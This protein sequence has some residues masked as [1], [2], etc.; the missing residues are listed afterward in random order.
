MNGGLFGGNLF[1][2]HVDMYKP[3]E[4]CYDTMFDYDDRWNSSQCYPRHWRRATGC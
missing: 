3:G 2:D 1:A 4:Y